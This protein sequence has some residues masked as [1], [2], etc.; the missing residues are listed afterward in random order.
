[1]VHCSG[2]AWWKSQA[3]ARNGQGGSVC[4]LMKDS[5][6]GTKAGDDAQ[7]RGNRRGTSCRTEM[8]ITPDDHDARCPGLQPGKASESLAER[9]VLFVDATKCGVGRLRPVPAAARWPALRHQ[10]WDVSDPTCCHMNERT[11]PTTRA[12][13]SCLRP[14]NG[15]G[16]QHHESSACRATVSPRGARLRAS[17]LIA[18]WEAPPQAIPCDPVPEI[19]NSFFPGTGASAPNR[20]AD[21]FCTP[22]VK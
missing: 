3:S 8:V 6:P 19:M 5:N 18:K 15:L 14:P 4:R 21:S 16:G 10:H 11:H 22:A 20:P 1:M 12:V 7:D 17:F 9:V 2:G 13:G